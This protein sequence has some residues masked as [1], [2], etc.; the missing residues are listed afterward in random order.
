MKTHS[1]IDVIGTLRLGDDKEHFIPAK[2]SSGGVRLPLD[3]S[4][5]RAIIDDIEQGGPISLALEEV[6]GLKRIGH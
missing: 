3:M 4:T 2:V 1:P 5:I 6:Y